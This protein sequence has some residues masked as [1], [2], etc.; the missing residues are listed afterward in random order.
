M[1]TTIPKEADAEVRQRR[2]VI[3]A[4]LLYRDGRAKDAVRRLR[5]AIRLAG[6]GYSASLC[7]FLAMAHH[8]H[9]DAAEARKFLAEMKRLEADSVGL[10]FLA[11]LPQYHLCREAEQVIGATIPGDR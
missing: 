8:H 4:A 11:R 9:G 5:E 1:L 2:T 10:A 6:G 7:A 3:L